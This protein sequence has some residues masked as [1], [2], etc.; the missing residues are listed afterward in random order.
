MA[1]TPHRR[2]AR[3]NVRKAAAAAKKQRTIARLNKKTRKAFG[4]EGAKA[5][6]KKRK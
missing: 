2:T 4:K 6:A 3:A 5:A 1:T